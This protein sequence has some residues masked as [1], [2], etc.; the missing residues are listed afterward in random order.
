MNIFVLDKDI[1]KCAEYHNDKHVVKMCLESAQ[2][3]CT[4]CHNLGM[5][6]P[7][8]PVHTNHPCTVWAM[9]SLGNWLWLRDYCFALNS[10]YLWRFDKGANHRA[11]DVVNKLQVPDMRHKRKTEHVICMPDEY[12]RDTVIDSYRA[13]YVWGKAS[14]AK[15][16]LPAKIPA[17]Y[18]SKKY[19][20]EDLCLLNKT[21]NG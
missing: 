11:W 1:G 21:T 10:E 16:S 17:W 2:I 7:W 8:K 20:K 6:V 4:V 18:S 13:Y 19:P 3:L 9:T 14:I 15:W 5:D 12:K